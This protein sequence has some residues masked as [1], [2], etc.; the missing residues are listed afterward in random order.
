MYGSRY[1]E[2]LRY[3]GVRSSDARLQRPEYLGGGKRDI[4]FSEVLQT[5]E[6]TDPVGAMKGHGISG[7]ATRPFRKFFE[8]H[9]I[10]MSVM[11]IR[12]QSIYSN[13]LHRSWLRETKE[14][15]FQKELQFVGQQEIKNGEVYFSND[16]LNYDTFG[17]GDRYSEYTHHPSTIAGDFRSTL[18]FW[19][20][21]RSFTSRPALNTTFTN[22]D[23]TDRI[24]AVPSEHTF[25]VASQ[26]KIIARRMVQSDPTARIL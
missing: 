20:A 7:M 3:L 14:D 26:Q 13:G 9:G 19:T 8:E 1:T 2:Y 22:C 12:P 6:G 10:V 5:A 15:Y 24:F 21:A 16:S 17:Y 25:W 18:D 11:S 4:S 23:P